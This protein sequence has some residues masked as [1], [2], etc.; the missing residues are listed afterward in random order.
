M[1]KYPVSDLTALAPDGRLGLG[2]TD[3]LG[4]LLSSVLLFRSELPRTCPLL[5]YAPVVG[6]ACAFHWHYEPELNFSAAA[7][8]V[9][10][11]CSTELVPAAASWI[12]VVV[13]L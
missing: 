6:R 4:P 8:M 3:E 5:K 11:D 7:A 12:A 2:A 1:S 9:R 13:V 10:I